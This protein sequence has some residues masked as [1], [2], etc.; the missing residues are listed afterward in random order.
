MSDVVIEAANGLDGKTYYAT[1]VPKQQVIEYRMAPTLSPGGKQ[2]HR[3]LVTL[4]ATAASRRSIFAVRCPPR[5]VV[6]YG[7]GRLEFDAFCALVLQIL[8]TCD[9]SALTTVSNSQAINEICARHGV[10]ADQGGFRASRL[11]RPVPF[12]MLF[13][14]DYTTRGY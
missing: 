14:R 12:L 5:L 1:I 4:K 11:L 9:M 3:A 2:P 8:S 7:I 13:D 10:I 6:C